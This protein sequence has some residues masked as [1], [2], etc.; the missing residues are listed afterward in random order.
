MLELRLRNEWMDE[1]R[2][3]TSA[4]TVRD[5]IA[6]RGGEAAIP[7]TASRKIQHAVSCLPNT[8]PEVAEKWNYAGRHR[9][10][11]EPHAV[12]NWIPTNGD[13]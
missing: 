8:Q 2:G 1:R 10:V 4:S 11:F 5:E 6:E 12:R 9:L 7:S 3:G 13:D